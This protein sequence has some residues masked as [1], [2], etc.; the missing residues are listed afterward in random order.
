M[1]KNFGSAEGKKPTVL[2]VTRIQVDLDIKDGFDRTGK[3]SYNRC[4][5]RFQFHHVIFGYIHTIQSYPDVEACKEYFFRA[6]EIIGG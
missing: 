4:I 2:A 5:F 3:V 6:R 1:Q